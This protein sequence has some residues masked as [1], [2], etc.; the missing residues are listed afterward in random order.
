M[1]LK[2]EQITHHHS[3]IITNEGPLITQKIIRILLK[4]P[5]HASSQ[6]THL[7]SVFINKQTNC[8]TQN[9][10]T[11]PKKHYERLFVVKNEGTMGKYWGK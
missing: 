3:T 4:E 7:S 11:R 1:F 8:L 6:I 2:Q 10:L 5:G 9:K